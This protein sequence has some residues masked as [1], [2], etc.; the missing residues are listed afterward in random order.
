LCDAEFLPLK[1]GV[2]DLVSVS[3]VLHHLPNPF[4]SMI[5]MLRVVKQHGFFLIIREPNLRRL[6]R[7]FDFFDNALVGKVVQS[8]SFLR[9]ESSAPMFHV[10][11]LDY[12]KVDIHCAAGF[13]VGLLADFIKSRRFK[14]ILARSYHWVF[15][16]S[17]VNWLERFLIKVDFFL[18]KV[19]L[20]DR[21]GRYVTVIASKKA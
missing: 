8:L 14:V 21:F 16:H 5:Y 17:A 18:E 2:A 6:R 13:R 7:F 12:D 15:P 9:S 1:T 19:P 3:S 20:S 10:E 11:E 4:V